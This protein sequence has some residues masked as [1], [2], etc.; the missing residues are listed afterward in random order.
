MGTQHS[1]YP[2]K[3]TGLSSTTCLSGR[4]CRFLCLVQELM[5]ERGLPKFLVL[6]SSP[7]T[8]QF[9]FVNICSIPIKWFPFS[10]S[11]T[12]M[13]WWERVQWITYVTRFFVSGSFWY[14]PWLSQVDS[15]LAEIDHRDA[16]DEY[17]RSSFW[18]IIAYKSNHL[19]RSLCGP[20][21]WA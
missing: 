20:L 15:V 9:S 11:F 7:T 3:T 10:Q 2:D 12:D 13:H 4:W 16:T 5:S 19:L 17:L 1:L 8:P 14:W 18:R 21:N 6:L